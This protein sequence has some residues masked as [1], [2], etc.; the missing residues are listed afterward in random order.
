[1]SVGQARADDDEAEPI[2]Y[3]GAFN[4]NSRE[5]CAKCGW[6]GGHGALAL[7]ISGCWVAF[8]PLRGLDL[9]P[10]GQGATPI[11]ALLHRLCV[12]SQTQT[13]PSRSQPNTNPNPPKPEPA[14]HKPESNM[15]ASIDVTSMSLLSSVVFVW[16]FGV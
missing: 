10:S 14:N 16:R 2:D 8:P 3:G 5:L 1:V 6:R 7:L 15:F 4:P 13:Q 9:S 11:Q 12:K